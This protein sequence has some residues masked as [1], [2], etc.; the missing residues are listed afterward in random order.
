[1]RGTSIIVPLVAVLL[2]LSVAAAPAAALQTGVQISPGSPASKEYSF[3]LSVLRAASRGHGTVPG[4]A[5]P[6]FGTGITAPAAHRSRTSNRGPRRSGGGSSGGS[7]Q[8]GAGGGK[9]SGSQASAA[10]QRS[11]IGSR[12]RSSS[13]VPQ[14]ALIGVP[15]LLAGLLLGVTIVAVR[16][17]AG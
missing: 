4:A 11:A 16:R 15:V 17:R 9:S 10:L 5:E 8:Q 14:E 7:S 1:M 3:P 6:L 2:G 12:V 13:S